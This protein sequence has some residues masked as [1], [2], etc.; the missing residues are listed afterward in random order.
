MWLSMNVI[1]TPDAEKLVKEFYEKTCETTS[2]T[3]K[4][5]EQIGIE[6]TKCALNSVSRLKAKSVKGI[7]AGAV[8][9]GGFGVLRPSTIRLIEVRA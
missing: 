5:F 7:F 1:Q 9:R 3:R 8:A 2:G 6:L 4:S